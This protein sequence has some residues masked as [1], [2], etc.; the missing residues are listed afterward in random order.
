MPTIIDLPPSVWGPIFWNTMHIITLGYP[1][2]P[3]EQTQTAAKEFFYSL[4]FLLPCDICK[5][6]YKKHITESPPKTESQ[7]ELI[8]WAFDLHNKV[9]QDLNKPIITYPEFMSHIKSLSNSSSSI[10][11]NTLLITFSVITA[12]IISYYLYKKYSK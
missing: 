8:H 3:D 9:N 5:A 12:G 6:H 1:V 10:P 7:K 11:N 4:Q 2:Q